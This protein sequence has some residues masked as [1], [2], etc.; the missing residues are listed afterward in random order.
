LEH[1]TR[2]D[3]S[4]N[5]IDDEG[6]R[7]L[8]NNEFLVNLTHLNLNTSGISDAGVAALANSRFLTNLTHLGLSDN[9]SRNFGVAGI[10][11]IASSPG[12]VHLTSLGLGLRNNMPYQRPDAAVVRALAEGT[13][14]T[15][16]VSLSLSNRR[17]GVEGA[18][19]IAGSE[20]FRQLV[21]INLKN[22]QI[23]NAGVTLL[24][25]SNI[26]VN[27]RELVLGDN[28]DISFP[29][30]ESLI[31][32]V[33]ASPILHI[34]VNEAALRRSELSPEELEAVRSESASRTLDEMEAARSES[35]MRFAVEVSEIRARLDLNRFTL[36]PRTT[37]ERSEPF[38]NYAGWGWENL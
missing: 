16:L 18:R 27:L 33:A 8:A 12:M 11:A 26:L 30:I 22:N 38:I 17:I 25:D 15:G 3:L 34:T 19:I 36:E 1:L 28:N 20:R 14:L 6:A 35:V 9:Y 32:W 37:W 7:A 31:L 4:S 29:G 24:K 2:L 13:S 23:T 5:R 21:R 10:T